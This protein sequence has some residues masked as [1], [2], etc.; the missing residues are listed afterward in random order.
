MRRIIGLTGGIG[1]GKSTVA[2]ML[3]DRGAH[4]IDVDG[5]ARAVIEPGGGA[6]EAVVERFGAD[7][8]T[9]GRIDRA[10]LA[11]EV[12]GD[13]AA[14]ADLTAISHPA[15]N[16]VMSAEVAAQA[17]DAV[18]VLDMAVLVEYPRLGRWGDGPEGGYQKVLV[19]EAPLEVR[20]DRLEAQRGM[21][22]DDALARIRSQVSDAERRRVADWVVDNGGDLDALAS[23]VAELWPQLTGW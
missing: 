23:R 16:E 20:L 15:S 19:V 17:P 18:V 6:H 7:I 11:A 5:V 10:A 3:A 21:A 1:T 8:V 4:V 12:F 13:P 2:A 9:D 14:L 22:R